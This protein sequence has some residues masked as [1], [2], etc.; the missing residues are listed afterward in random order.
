MLLWDVPQTNRIIAARGVVNSWP[1]CGDPRWGSRRVPPLQGMEWDMVYLGYVLPNKIQR[2]AKQKGRKRG[3]PGMP[4][5]PES[6]R[7]QDLPEH[8]S[9]QSGRSYHHLLF[10]VEYVWG[11]H[12]YILR[13]S[14]ATK[15]LRWC[16]HPHV[17]PFSAARLRG[18]NR[19][20]FASTAASSDASR[21]NATMIPFLTAVLCASASLPIDAPV[22]CFVARLA[23][24]A[25][26]L[27]SFALSHP[28]ANQV[29]R[30]GYQMAICLW[31]CCVV[32]GHCVLG[33][34]CDVSLSL[35][36]LTP[37]LSLLVTLA[38]SLSSNHFVVFCR[39]KT[40][41]L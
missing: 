11:L 16:V 21:Y 15:L 39:L 17:V 30:G 27:R 22:D 12:A 10:R 41:S 32:R 5:L 35:F 40:R 9:K 2:Q 7:H 34:V 3:G 23:A 31:V 18:T 4:Y 25:M 24:Q 20:A 36:R 29:R 33:D 28:I 14:G 26:T 19:A 1:A 38:L 37:S 8:K 6:V 13:Q